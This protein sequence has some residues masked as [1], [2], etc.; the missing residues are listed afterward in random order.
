MFE[1]AKLLPAPVDWQGA[2]E[3][4]LTTHVNKHLQKQSEL[5]SGDPLHPLHFLTRKTRT[6]SRDPTAKR[7]QWAQIDT[8]RDVP[9]R[10]FILGQAHWDSAA[11]LEQ[12]TKLSLDPVYLFDRTEADSPAQCQK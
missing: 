1:L 12:A 3:L 2:D 8:T 10:I 11:L 6:S 4:A 9:E 5:L 7:P